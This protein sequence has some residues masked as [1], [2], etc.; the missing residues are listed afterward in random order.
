MR[1]PV[2]L[3]TSAALLGLAAYV[4]MLAP[5]IATRPGRASAGPAE[6][7]A[8]ASRPP[9]P[10]P[11]VAV[12]APAGPSP[13]RDR[14]RQLFPARGRVLFGVTTRSGPHDFAELEA[15]QTAAGRRPDV[16]LF[17]QGWA[18]DR[19]DR[20]LLDGVARRGM[21]PMI[22]WEPWDYQQE[23]R[24][25]LR[26]GE[27]PGY[28]LSR[29]AGG[30]FDAYIR[31]WAIGIRQV[32]YPVAIRFA[33]EMNGYWYPWAEAAN[34]N[35]PGEYV[36]AWR[37]VHDVFTRAGARNVVWVWSPN[38]VYPG[39]TPLRQLYPGDAYVD[40]AGVVGYY[41]TDRNLTGYRTFEQVFAPTIRELRAVTRKPIVL[42]EVAATDRDRRKAAWVRD[43]FRALPRHPEIIG[44]VWYE[45]V[46]EADWRIASSEPARAAFAAGVADARYGQPF[47]PWVRPR[48]RL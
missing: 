47:T 12:P 9:E 18:R 39:A 6:P 4:F 33:H 17:S 3:A 24:L 10:A 36:K 37:H 2:R 13:G 46:K 42:T 31:S 43:F 26:R 19:F 8:T 29:I 27:Q 23:S 20:R 14:P 22:G 44:F 32:G 11:A 45:V 48:A 30:A 15:F 28:A 35:R 5:S 1:H 41:G 34:G 21:L 38:V 7:S 25:D 40:W 16:M